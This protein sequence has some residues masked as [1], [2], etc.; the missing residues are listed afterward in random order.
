MAKRKT[1]CKYIHLING[2]P[3]IFDGEQICFA[4][5]GMPL[6][7]MLRDSLD[8][9]REN[10]KASYRYRVQNGFTLEGFEYSYLRVNP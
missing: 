6:A 7:L 4:R 2:E 3:A 5:H 8:E 1:K 10:Q 9:I